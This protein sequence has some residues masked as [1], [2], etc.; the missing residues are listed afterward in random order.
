MDPYYLPSVKRVGIPDLSD[1]ETSDKK[2][3]RLGLG[4][5]FFDLG[6][7]PSFDRFLPDELADSGITSGIHFP[8]VDN[9][10]GISDVWMS[11]PHTPP[12]HHVARFDHGW[13][14]PEPGVETVCFGVV[15][16]ISLPQWTLTL[17]I[18]IDI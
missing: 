16:R 11:D 15:G 13:Q 12:A 3:A 14:L 9:N 17:V 4:V 10:S 8:V 18:F 7:S 1:W 5:D 6:A 2:R